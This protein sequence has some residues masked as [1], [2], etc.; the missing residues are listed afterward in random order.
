LVQGFVLAFA[1]ARVLKDAGYLM[2]D[3]GGTDSSPLMS[4][5]REIALEQWRPQ[6]M[7][8]YICTFALCFPVLKIL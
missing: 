5:K 6:A 4:Y 7:Q 1:A 2:W 8:R 3:L